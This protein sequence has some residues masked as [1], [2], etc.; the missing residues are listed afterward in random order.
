M[1]FIGVKISFKMFFFWWEVGIISVE[2]IEV[3]VFIW[4]LYLCFVYLSVCDFRML[5]IFI[6]E[7][8]RILLV[9]LELIREVILILLRFVL[10]VWILSGNF[11]EGVIVFSIEFF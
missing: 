1:I 3:W 6:D 11:K 9:S 2:E 10:W 8:V 4:G 5:F 7:F